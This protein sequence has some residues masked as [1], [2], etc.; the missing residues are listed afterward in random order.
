MTALYIAIGLIAIGLIIFIHEA[1]HFLAAKKVGIRVE[2]F[3]LGFDPPIRGRPMRFFSKKIGE[4]EYVLGM[5][6]FGGY[7][8]MAGE[9]IP[10]DGHTPAPDEL[11]AKSIGARA[12]VF[13]AGAL[14]NF[15]SAF[16][17]FIIAFSLGVVFTEPVLGPVEPGSAIW[18]AGLRPGDRVLELNED[19]VV[20]FQELIVGAALSGRREPMQLKV[21]RV[22][23]PGGSPQELEF[24]V[25][26]IYD[27]K[28]GFA[29]TGVLTGRPLSDIVGESPEGSPLHTAGLSKGD[30]LVGLRVAG[31]QLPPLSPQLLLSEVVSAIRMFP[32]Q[33]L[34]LEIESQGERRWISLTPAEAKDSKPLPF[35]RVSGVL[36][37]TGGTTLRSVDASSPVH[38]QL[39][40]HETIVSI[41]GTPV[42]SLHWLDI[43]NRFPTDQLSLVLR[44]PTGSVRELTLPRRDLVGWLTSQAVYWGYHGA[45]VASLLAGSTLEK[46]GMRAGDVLLSVNGKP[47]FDPKELGALVP[48]A[49][50]ETVETRLLRRNEAS[51]E[52]EVTLLE[53]RAGDLRS[54]ESVRWRTQPPFHTVD[55]MGPAGQAGIGPG[56][57]VT[58]FAGKPIHEW[59]E[60]H[61]AVQDAE[62][63]E[64][65]EIRWIAADSSEKVATV[66]VGASAY[67]NPGLAIGLLE[68]RFRV[69]I[70]ESFKLGV[71]RS[72]LVAQQVFMTLRSLIRRDVSPKNL[73]GPVGI[74]RLLTKV[75]EQPWGNLLYW[76]AIIS[77]NLGLLNLMPFPI[78]DGGHLLFLLIEKIKGS[79]VSIRIQERVTGV[80]LFLILGLA[81]YVT[82]NDLSNWWGG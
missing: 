31:K 38:S 72:W 43:E 73:S 64:S 50:G 74:T 75:A 55:P 40:V 54:A 47:V 15:L 2:R 11:L 19:P 10:E 49:D 22:T 58:E 24:E 67:E 20:D 77:I 69:S 48:N 28:L 34:E 5:I 80:A 12:L 18:N 78:L 1:G 21:E 3:A 61:K 82:W 81:I 23:E 16:V 45:R 33:P 32:S 9:M 35:L 68:K 66:R 57:I 36:S 30:R 51:G 62:I 42:R 26:P 25:Q 46:A 41:N 59:T 17:F 76:M 71:E 8:K 56:A 60:F 70:L 63:G 39:K 4:T 7:V 29:R 6:P 37:G 27:D 44:D 53:I 13:A 14:M 65:V 79:P 52:Q